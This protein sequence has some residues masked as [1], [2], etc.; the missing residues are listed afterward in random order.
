[1]RLV[2]VL[3]SATA[4]G[5][6]HRALSEAVERAARGAALSVEPIDLAMCTVAP[7]DGRPPEALDDDT[8]ATAGPAPLGAGGG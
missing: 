6:L 8:A 2:A 3:G 7:A 4:A 5:R 1:M